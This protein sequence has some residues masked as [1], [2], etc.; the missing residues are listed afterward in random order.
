MSR[1]PE[2]LIRLYVNAVEAKQVCADVMLDAYTHERET[3]V[4]M[5]EFRGCIR[6]ESAFYEEMR[7]FAEETR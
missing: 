4:I 6:R 5:A 2:E 1:T 3:K 7:K